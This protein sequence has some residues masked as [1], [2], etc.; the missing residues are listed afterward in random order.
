MSNLNQDSMTLFHAIQ[1]AQK[2]NA[3]MLQGKGRMSTKFAT[4]RTIKY[5][6]EALEQA[7]DIAKS[8]E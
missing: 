6:T 3:Y 2:W 1:D 8:L 7:Q 4:D 5:L